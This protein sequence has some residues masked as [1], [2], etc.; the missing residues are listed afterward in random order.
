MNKNK[1]RK[2]YED[3]VKRPWHW[4]DVVFMLTRPTKIRIWSKLGMTIALSEKW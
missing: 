3:E 2:I 4:K 1:Y